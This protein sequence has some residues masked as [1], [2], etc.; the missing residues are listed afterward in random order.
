RGCTAGRDEGRLVLRQSVELDA[1]ESCGGGCAIRSQDR[2][3][4]QPNRSRAELQLSV[5]HEGRGIAAEIP[6]SRPVAFVSSRNR[7]CSPT[8][9]KPAFRGLGIVYPDVCDLGCDLFRVV[10]LSASAADS[11]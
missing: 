9:A 3:H 7:W 2:L 10:A 5:F 4:V 6:G 1:S 11:N 8:S